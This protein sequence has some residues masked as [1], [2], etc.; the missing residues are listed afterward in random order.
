MKRSPELSKHV[1]NFTD[2]T[3]FI[4]CE[5]PSPN[6]LTFTGKMFRVDLKNGSYEKVG[7]NNDHLLVCGT[8]VKKTAF[9]Y[10]CCVYAG[11]ETKVRIT[12]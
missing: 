7:L 5:N 2:F 8:R 6:L 1:K 11:E 12:Y 4:E 9:V 3:G 10:A